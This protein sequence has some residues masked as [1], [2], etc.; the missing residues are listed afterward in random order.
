MENDGSNLFIDFVNSGDAARHA[1]A[2]ARSIANGT[3]SYVGASVTIYREDGETS[4]EWLVLISEDDELCV[5]DDEEEG[6][7]KKK[8]RDWE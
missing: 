3:L 4:H 1:E 7:E 6:R 2:L 5:D 8:E